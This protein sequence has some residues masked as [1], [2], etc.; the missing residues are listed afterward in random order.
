[1]LDSEATRSSES[2]E[3]ALITII[4]VAA[5]LSSVSILLMS[6]LPRRSASLAP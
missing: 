4:A 2:I 1:M 3:R 6:F 5:L